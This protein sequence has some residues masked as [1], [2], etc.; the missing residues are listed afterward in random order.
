MEILFDTGS[1]DDEPGGM[2]KVGG[3]GH[4]LSFLQSIK[5]RPHVTCTTS[6]VNDSVVSKKDGW[7]YTA[8]IHFRRPRWVAWPLAAWK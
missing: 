6:G 5:V 3:Q 4:F 8:M 1:I 2:G 7:P